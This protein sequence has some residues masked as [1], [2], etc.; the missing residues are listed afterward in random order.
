MKTK[1]SVLIIAFLVLCFAGWMNLAKAQR[2]SSSIKQTWEYQTVY[3]QKAASDLV[4]PLNRLGADG[5]ELVS[6]SIDSQGWIIAYLKR[7]K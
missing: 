7:P 1:T 5:W 4:P 2:G 6:V 3:V